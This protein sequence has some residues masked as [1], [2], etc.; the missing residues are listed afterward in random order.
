MHHRLVAPTLD[1]R[2]TL[3]Q[4]LRFDHLAIYC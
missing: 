4:E 2:L 1:I 3:G